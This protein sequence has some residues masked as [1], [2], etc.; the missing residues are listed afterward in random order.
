MRKISSI[1]VILCV[2]AFCLTGC[3]DVDYQA[4]SDSLSELP[5][6]NPILEAAPV[7][8]ASP[9]PTASD[10]P[11]EPKP[12]A[13][14]ANME[15]VAVLYDDGTVK[16]GTGCDEHKDWEGVIDIEGTLYG[17]IGLKNDGTVIC[18]DYRDEDAEE[19]QDVVAISAYPTFRNH[20]NAALTANGKVFVDATIGDPCKDAEEWEDIVQIDVGGNHIVGLKADGTVV[21]AGKNDHD[22]CAVNNWKDIVCVAASG[23][24]TVGVQADGHVLVAGGGSEDLACSQYIDEIR[25][26]TDIE[27]VNADVQHCVGKK[28]DGTFIIASSGEYQYDV[29]QW[30]DIVDYECGL[31]KIIAIGKDGS[32]YVSGNPVNGGVTAYGYGFPFYDPE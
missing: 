27:S 15:D 4:L 22:E 9:I 6:A 20:E 7:P 30:H 18:S 13:C 3:S 32:V 31:Y 19:W 24:Y 17:F 25:A 2:F 16:T 8:D 12:I 28:K 26:W 14:A 10:I 29:D 23:G 1:I 5:E 21:A 11:S